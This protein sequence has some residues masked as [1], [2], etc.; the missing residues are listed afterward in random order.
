MNRSKHRAAVLDGFNRA[1]KFIEVSSQAPG[2]LEVLVRVRAIAINPFDRIVQ[3]LGDL[4]TP[5]VKFPAV[6]GSDVAGEVI[7]VGEGC[8]RIKVGDRIL[9]LALGVD[10]AGNRAVEGAF[11]E[12]VIL[13]EAC[14]SRLPERIAF[15]D[16]AVLPLALAT[17]SSGLFLKGQLGLD[18]SALNVAST[19][20]VNEPK[21]SVV[22]WGGATSVGTVAIQLAHAAG[23]RVLSTAS[24]HNHAQIL[25]LG[26]SAVEDYKDKKAVERLLG[27]SKG[28]GL[29]GVMAIGVGSGQPC[30]RIAAG[31]RAKPKVAMASAPISL[32]SAPIGP[33]A[34][35]RLVNLPRLA[36]GFAKLAVS[37]GFTRVPT[38]SIWGTAL[39]E[40][41]LGTEIFT[42][43]A[44][45]ALADGRLKTVPEPFITGYRLED[46]PDSME[47]LR[48]GISARKVVIEL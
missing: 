43:F 5:W 22:I 36:G 7:A 41:S 23:Y 3:T 6:L 11:Q 8:Q 37:A 18:V 46:I 12:Q 9:G 19:R 33:Q 16:A 44:E 20:T 34:A 31:H 13:R 25:R 10:R 4:I 47:V 35:W 2:P 21:A 45:T 48:K 42:Q 15:V 28:T 39:V 24:P 32:D 30:L 40:E 17:A 14:C 26:A 1:L 38:S 27:A 29:A